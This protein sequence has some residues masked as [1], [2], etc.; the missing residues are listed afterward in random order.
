MGTCF[1]KQTGNNSLRSSGRM[2]KRTLTLISVFIM[3][4]SFQCQENVEEFCFEGIKYTNFFG[5]NDRVS[6]T[7]ACSRCEQD[8]NGRLAQMKNRRIFDKFQ[9]VTEEL[10]FD[11]D[12][13]VLPFWNGKSNS[14]S[15]GIHF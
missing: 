9:A 1:I 12:F 3:L 4:D 15:L 14:C 7:E 10:T 13:F 6:F 5:S 8:V 11:F 2:W